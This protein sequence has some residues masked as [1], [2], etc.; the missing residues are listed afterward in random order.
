MNDLLRLLPVAACLGCPKAAPVPE[1][2]EDAPIEVGDLVGAKGRMLTGGEA[3]AAMADM[4]AIRDRLLALVPAEALDEARACGE[5]VRFDIVYDAD[6]SLSFARVYDPKVVMAHARDS[7]VPL[8]P[9]PVSECAVGRLE[10][11]T[12]THDEDRSGRARV[13]LTE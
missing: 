13:T 3:D 7:S 4:V 6:G 11:L 10:G 5:T 9:D 2:P 12:L 1:A 8:E